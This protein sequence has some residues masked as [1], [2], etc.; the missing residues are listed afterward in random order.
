MLY[1][2]NNTAFD[3]MVQCERKVDQMEGS[4]NAGFPLF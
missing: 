4:K 1:T 2:P 3:N